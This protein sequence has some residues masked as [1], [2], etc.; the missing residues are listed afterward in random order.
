MP[1]SATTPGCAGTCNSAPEH[2]A[3]RHPYDVGTQNMKS[4]AAQW[5]ACVYP[6]QR[7]APYLAIRRA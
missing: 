2:V 4:I 5:L 6:C 3:F 1:G 7:F